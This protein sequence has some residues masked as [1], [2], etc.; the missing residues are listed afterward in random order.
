MSLVFNMVGGG[1]S[2][3]IAYGSY[4]TTPAS[5]G[6]AGYGKNIELTVTP[7]QQIDLVVGSGGNRISI[8]SKT[9][10][11]GNTGGTTSF[12]KITVPGG[13][14]GRYGSTSFA[15]VDPTP[16]ADGG[17]GSDASPSTTGV[18]RVYGSCGTKDAYYFYTGGSYKETSCASGGRSQ[19]PR[20]SQNRFDPSMVTLCAGGGASG[21][22][23]Q[24]VAAMPDGTKGGN[25]RNSSG[26]AV[27]GNDA[28]G[29]GNGGGAVHPGDTPS[30]TR[31]SYSG[32]GSPGMILIYAKA[33]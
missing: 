11:N 25:G 5:G 19:S 20:E 23:A 16:G 13:S 4:G 28:T 30:T 2:G 12:N 17:Q 7:G 21:S 24:A 29:N 6:A 32:A 14:G 10:Y 8:S 3:A 18:A 31:I 22:T 1:G 33:V 27:I 9:A 15:N 26:A